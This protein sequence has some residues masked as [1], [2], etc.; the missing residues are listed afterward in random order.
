[1]SNSIQN[2]IDYLK[3]KSKQYKLE[4][5]EDQEDVFMDRVTTLMKINI[6]LQ[7]ARGLA[8]EELFRKV[9][10]NKNS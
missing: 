2:D 7:N 4:I 10:D 6:N 1:M 3:V 9:H 5:T 8:F